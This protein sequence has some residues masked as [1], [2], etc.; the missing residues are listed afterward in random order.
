MKL[1]RF[2]QL[3]ESSIVLKDILLTPTEKLSITQLYPNTE[4]VVV[5]E[6]GKVLVFDSE[7]IVQEFPGYYDYE[8]LDDFKESTYS[9]FE[10]DKSI[11]DFDKEYK[12]LKDINPT[13]YKEISN[14]LLDNVSDNPGPDIKHIYIGELFKN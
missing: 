3:N 7:A 12:D 8:S 1:K 10:A 14:Y 13:H 5:W 6:D 2:K 4:F 9:S 11:H